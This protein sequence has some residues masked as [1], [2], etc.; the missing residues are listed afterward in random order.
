MSGDCKRETGEEHAKV[1]S[2]VIDGVDSLKGQTKLRITSLASDGETRR[3]TSFILLTFTK[4]LQ[5]NSPIYP[6]LK[7]LNFLNL[8]V[9][10][11]D[12]T[13]DKDWKHIFKRWRNL[14][15]RQRGVVVN[16]KRITP[17]IIRDHFKSAGLSVDH[18]RSIFNPDDQQ[19][20][21]MA[22]DMLK[23]I[24]NLP[25]TSKNDRRGFIDAR[26]A[27]WILGKLLFHLV[28]PY[29]GVDLSLSEQVEHLS[30]AAH[31]CLILFHLAGKEF[32]P[33]NLY[34]DIMIMIKNAIFCIA[35]AK[36]DDPDGEFWLILLGTD[37]LE[38]LFGILRTM[39]GNDANLDIL[40]LVSRLAGTT[41]VSNILGKYPQ[42]DRSPRHLKLPAMSRDSNE[43][44]DSADH[45]KP[46]SWRGN[47]KLKDVSLQTSWNRGRRIIEQ[48][49]KDLI[50]ILLK[51]DD[52]DGIDILS[53]FG[54]LLF[55]V[56]LADD[57]IDESL[58]PPGPGLGHT[59]EME[60]NCHE[61]EIRVDIEDEL[62]AANTEE[63][64]D[65]AAANWNPAAVQQQP[66]FDSKV[67][68]K[69]V[70][71]NKARALKNFS[72]YRKQTGSTD[73]LKRVQSVARFSN[74]E[75]L[76]LSSQNHIN[77][78]QVDDSQKI[79]ISD[80]I[81]SLLRIGN[82]LWLCIGEVNGLRVDG[83]PVDYISFEMLGEETVK[84]SYQML[85]L[86]PATLV[87]DPN[88]I[89]DWRTYTMEEHSFIVPG[90]I[91][92]SINPITSNIALSMPF[93][94]LQSS[95]LVALA[96]SL[97]QSLTVTDLKNVPKIAQLNE[98]PYR[99]ASGWLKRILKIDLVQNAHLC[100]YILFY[101]RC[102]FY[103][104]ERPKLRKN[105]I[106]NNCRLHTMLTNCQPRSY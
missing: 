56:P 13:C 92:Q 36:V 54:T 22:F 66:K 19:D 43:I 55:D 17:D 58:E 4:E 99:E 63:L 32:I 23:D 7:P 104:R 28:Y 21:K 47:V 2:T 48:E 64:Q 52:L 98:Y 6:F 87:D 89:H 97:F 50:Y 24:W 16:G 34:I 84:V 35:K 79:I 37:R 3:G 61:K 30:A 40:Q 94:L 76:F 25:R 9:G 106:S 103:L 39:V 95:V 62:T 65:L 83:Q 73:R 90:R 91:V 1:I 93:Y 70:A 18:I 51:L 96:A 67:M 60:S 14:L 53:P 80:P 82:D 81:V 85:G 69:G 8:Y 88:G 5:Q 71:I 45:I 74:T 100:F 86:R 29:L 31:L 42:W 78:T 49:C 75:D 72:K 46:A 11:D 59:T 77:S 33:T 12:L 105:W 38:E 20:V 41:E 27:L 26:E 102:M 57:D 68:I 10:D 101:R 44:P 15:L